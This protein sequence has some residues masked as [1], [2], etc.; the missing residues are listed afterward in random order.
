VEGQEFYQLVT[1]TNEK[2]YIYGEKPLG[3][4]A[5]T[6]GGHFKLSSRRET[7]SKPVTPRPMLS[8]L[9]STPRCSA[10]AV[11]TKQRATR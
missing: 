8:E 1:S 4:V 2:R 10:I 11:P 9:S 7:A 5:Y 3:M 6:K